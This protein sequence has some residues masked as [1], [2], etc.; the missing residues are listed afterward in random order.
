MIGTIC[1]GDERPDHPPF[2]VEVFKGRFGTEYGPKR[3]DRS[4]GVQ[5]LAYAKKCGLAYRVR[6]RPR[7]VLTSGVE[8]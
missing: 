3:P 7:D 1:R 2:F 8:S 6:V 4:T 5:Y